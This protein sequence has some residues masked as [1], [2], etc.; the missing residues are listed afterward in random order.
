MQATGIFYMFY[1]ISIVRF[2]SDITSLILVS[3]NYVRYSPLD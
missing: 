3:E 1:E 2:Q